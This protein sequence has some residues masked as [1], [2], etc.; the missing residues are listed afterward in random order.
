[1]ERTLGA[2][3]ALSILLV[4]GCASTRGRAEGPDPSPR[5]SPA[6]VVRIVVQALQGNDAEDRGI[7]TVFR[8]ASPEN[9]SVTGPLPR[10]AA[11]IRSPLYQAMLNHV[12]AFYD[13]MEVAGD[14]ARQQVAFATPTGWA[15]TYVFLLKRQ[16]AGEYAGCWMT[17]RVTV[18][19]IVR[20]PQGRPV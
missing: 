2:A 8:F 9:R 15:V 14:L 20:L 19:N 12:S 6:E 7:A 5:Y 3:A 11:M 1:M 4:S 10:F 17:E 18:V 16:E 13:D